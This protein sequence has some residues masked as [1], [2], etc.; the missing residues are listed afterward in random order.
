MYIC[1]AVVIYESVECKAQ[2]TR[3]TYMADETI[4]VNVYIR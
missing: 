1:I 3:E 4:H 2:F